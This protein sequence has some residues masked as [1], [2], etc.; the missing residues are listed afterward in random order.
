[1][2]LMS[3]FS[4]FQ[5]SLGETFYTVGSAY[6]D[7]LSVTEDEVKLT[8]SECG[9]KLILWKTCCKVTTHYFALLK[10]SIG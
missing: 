3:F 9:L 4:N 7:A 8:F 6:F 10:K 1:M 2:Y 5:G